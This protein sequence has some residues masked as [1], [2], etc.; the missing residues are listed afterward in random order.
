MSQVVEFPGSS[1]LAAGASAYLFASGS[2]TA[3][4]TASSVTEGTNAKSR[5]D[6]TFSGV[7]PGT[8][9]LI[10]EDAGGNPFCIDVVTLTA[11]GTFPTQS[12]LANSSS[13]SGI[14]PLTNMP[15]SYASGTLGYLIGR[16]SSG[17]VTITK[18][19]VTGPNEIRLTRKSDNFSA[20]GQAVVITDLANIWP[21]LTGATV[22]FT[23]KNA[24]EQILI[25]PFTCTIAVATGNAKQIVIEPPASQLAVPPTGAVP[26]LWD[27]LAVL[28]NGHRVPLRAGKLFIDD[29]VTP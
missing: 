20:D 8:Y 16:L 19:N 27:L 15:G 5:Y 28:G 13:G 29:N 10:A 26:L 14:D 2:D 22:Y 7:A 24:A 23:A 12:L 3:V 21:T 11:S 25:G 6:A 18:T 1:G 9:V 4:A 17:I